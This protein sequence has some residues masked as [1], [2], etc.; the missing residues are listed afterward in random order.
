MS[1]EMQLVAGDTAVN[2]GVEK[3]KQLID[4]ANGDPNTLIQLRRQEYNRLATE[5]PAK[6]GQDADSWSKR[7]DDLQQEVGQSPDM[8]GRFSEQQRL[9]EKMVTAAQGYFKNLN[10][11]PAGT[12][13]THDPLLT[14]KLNDVIKDP[15]K[16]GDFVGASLARQ[17]AVGVPQQ[18][19]TALPSMVATSMTNSI[20][21]DPES[22]PQKLND[23]Q[24]QT[25][26]YWPEV[27]KSMVTHGGMPTYMQSVA[28][29]GSDPTT[30]RDANLLAR[31]K[32]EDTK[33]KTDDDLLG[34]QNIKDINKSIQSDPDVNSLMLSLQRSGA[35]AS[36]VDD[37]LHSIQSL[38]YAKKYYDRDNAAAAN[39]ATAFTSKYEFL[40]NGGA[41]IPKDAF[42]AVTRNAQVA[43]DQID[44]L[45]VA[46][47]SYTSGIAGQP[48]P[49][50]YY[51]WVK[52][53]PTWVTSPD[54][55]SIILKDPQNR[56]V[57]GKDGKPISIKFN[58]AAPPSGQ[59]SQMS[60]IDMWAA[61]Q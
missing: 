12:I 11:D 48:K 44:K 8:V 21:S 31:W 33:G 4:Q 42:D 23:L 16:L 56:V 34:S 59:G 25:G 47:M 45:A 2:M 9:Y 54:A 52:N 51:A 18:A 55:S 5:N 38:A 49:E 26:D 53:S 20:M 14:Q 15:S 57:T 50:E 10:D 43:L 7:M 29:L 1:P 41:R 19:R 30:L 17:E 61:S 3:A 32:G 24:K 27:Y 58:Q 36:Q 13:M 37:T 35:S 28:V 6:Y 39:A 46:P 40:P 60:D 22:A